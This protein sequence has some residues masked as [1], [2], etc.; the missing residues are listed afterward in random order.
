MKASITGAPAPTKSRRKSKSAAKPMRA[1]GRATEAG[2]S[3]QAEVGMWLA[4]NMLADQPV[5]QKF[6]LGHGERLASIRFESGKGV[7]DVIGTLSGGGKVAV[8][9]KTSL[10]LSTGERSDFRK[11][12]TQMVAE[13]VAEPT[14][15]PAKS[16]LVIAVPALASGTL[17]TLAAACRRVA[18]GGEAEL[19]LGSQNERDAFAKFKECVGDAY[20][21]QAPSATPDY[22]RLAQLLRVVRLDRGASGSMRTEGAGLLGRALFGGS[23][24]GSQPLGD[25]IDFIREQ[26]K[27]G[28][29][30]NAAQFL[31]ELR[32]R[33]HV[34]VG[35]PRFDVDIE[36]LRARTVEELRQLE[37]F[38]EL[39]LRRYRL[40]RDCQGELLSAVQDGSLLVIGEPGAGKSGMLSTLAEQWTDRGPVIALS[41][42]RFAGVRHQADLATALRIDHD[43]DE[44]L[45]AWPGA[46]DGLLI[47]DALDAARGGVAEGAFVELIERVERLAP[48]WRVVASVRTFDLLNGQRLGGLMRGAPPSPVHSHERAQG[49]RHF[50]VPELQEAELAAVARDVPELAPI[51]NGGGPALASLLSNIFNLSLAADLI[52]GGTAAT[53]LL[54]ISTQSDLVD[55]YEDRRLKDVAARNAMIR[56]IGTMVDKASLSLR[57]ADLDHP[58]LDSLLASGIIVERDDRYSFA[59]HILFDHAAGRYFV[60]GDDADALVGQLKQLGAKAFMLSPALRF[61]LERV[62][63]RDRSVGHASSWSLLRRLA[64]GRDLGPI[65]AASALRIAAEQVS[66]PEDVGGL[67]RIVGTADPEAL[68]RMLYHLTRF[69]TMK[70]EEEPLTIA[71]AQA[72]TSLARTLAAAGKREF[73]EPVRFFLQALAG[74]ADLSDVATLEAFG[75]A[76]RVALT[77]VHAAPEFRFARRMLIGFVGRSF[78]SDVDASREALL[79]LLTT[80]SLAIFGHEDA[81]AIAEAL[82]FIVAIDPAF[83]EQVFA[84]IFNQ[85]V[86]PDDKTD[87]GSGRILALTSTRAQDFKHSYWL[88][89]RAF[90]KLLPIDSARAAA[91]LSAVSLSKSRDRVG[92]VSYLT[93]DCGGGSDVTIIEDGLDYVDWRQKRPYDKTSEPGIA[94]SFVQHI[95]KAPHGEL[96]RIIQVARAEK[97]AASVWRRLFG[98][99]LATDRRGAVDKLLW[100]VAA[101][102]PVI[103]SRDL[104][105]D[106]IDYLRAVYPSIDSVDREAFEAAVNAHEPK[107]KRRW[108]VMRDRLVSALPQAEIATANLRRRRSDLARKAGLHGNPAFVSFGTG[109]GRML[110]AS[111]A[112]T[113]VLPA[114][115]SIERLRR[116]REAYRSKKAAAKLPMVWSAIVAAVKVADDAGVAEDHLPRLWDEIAESFVTLIASNEFTACGVKLPTVADALTLFRRIAVLPYPSS[117]EAPSSWNYGARVHAGK[118]VAI[119]AHRYLATEPGLADDLSTL[120]AD[121]CGAVRSAV[122]ERLRLLVDVDADLMWALI[123][124]VTDNEGDLGVLT[125]FVA[126][127]FGWLSS[128]AP[129]RVTAQLRLIAA[130]VD[131]SEGNSHLWDVI[132]QLAEMLA[133]DERQDDARALIEEWAS[134]K[135]IRTKPLNDVTSMLRSALFHSYLPEDNE[136][137]ASGERAKGIGQFVALEAAAQLL[138]AKAR[139]AEFPDEGPER[140]WT[141]AAYVAADSAL[142]HLV[143]QLFFGSGAHEPA[144]GLL[145]SAE[146]KIAFLDDWSSTLAAV[147]QAANPAT[148]QH[149]RELYEHLLDA[150]PPRLF[151]RICQF[152]LGPA[153]REYYQHE[154]LAANDVVKFVRR[155]LADYRWL[156]DDPGRRDRLTALLDM[157]ADAGWPEAMRL[158][159]ELPDLL[160]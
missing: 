10:A 5:G 41:L 89:E 119:L 51:L 103:E 2:M 125:F 13:V 29:P 7:D 19:A 97:L 28:H 87:F 108:K 46:G 122:A 146:Q 8:Q 48:R 95:A 61:A 21:H 141:I 158:L 57:V 16:A 40:G 143:N 64:E 101:N 4:A 102:P 115:K 106:A 111:A 160:R 52:A 82:E 42:D 77:F 3:F 96:E 137:H 128:K 134:A 91:T 33:G 145:T 80:E 14:L 74:N 75:E 56:A 79:P 30:A 100:P 68:G 159:W 116:T 81:P 156:F 138:D 53:G 94:E 37:R 20:R 127:T 88:L 18:A 109:G 69:V 118:A 49:I 55:A 23:D 45:A 148:I 90:R 73:V 117:D 72:W 1:G 124:R 43:V 99:L 157:F 114:D 15:D 154:Q 65:A 47:I 11:T 39:P 84:A 133:V 12:V 62:W 140:T 6:G 131:D 112:S 59:H 149:L 44:V 67:Q 70:I 152:I 93:V 151:E 105:R 22:R 139:L 60:E 38:A 104:G 150:D 50:M 9:C 107:D 58:G 129:D 24:K 32:R 36:R 66:S 123:G 142:G 25:L 54:G 144:S 147:E 155:M 110:R 83:A 135:P 85:P 34:D 35:S 26:I 120:L 31:A 71:A 86:P 98:G 121:P 78:A 17:D 130:R 126:H 92:E 76:S 113:G 136:R 63:R 132:G 27:E 153:A